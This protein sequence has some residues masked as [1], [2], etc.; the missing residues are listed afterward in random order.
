MEA[1]SFMYNEFYSAFKDSK[2]IV[3]GRSSA[4]SKASVVKAYDWGSN[5]Y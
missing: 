2:Q 1:E 5:G 4:T 3:K